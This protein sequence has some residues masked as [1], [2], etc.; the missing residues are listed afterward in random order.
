MRV[1]QRKE[2]GR[3]ETRHQK[4]LCRNNGHGGFWSPLDLNSLHL[5]G[6]LF[7]HI[8]LQ[9]QSF[10]TMPRSDSES[11]VLD[12]RAKY[13]LLTAPV[14][15]HQYHISVLKHRQKKRER[16]WFLTVYVRWLDESNSQLDK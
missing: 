9:M 14:Q 7:S 10:I 5:S 8:M 12:I 4:E 16:R 11:T 3:E 15:K 2:G 1:W 13:E 6:S